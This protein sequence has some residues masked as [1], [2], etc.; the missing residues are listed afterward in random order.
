MNLPPAHQHQGQTAT[1]DKLKWER[2]LMHDSA[3]EYTPGRT[4][5]V[6]FTCGYTQALS[7][8]VLEANCSSMD[9]C[10]AS[11][12]RRVDKLDGR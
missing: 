2:G 9:P 12:D 8:T 4:H 7:A 6:R 5:A 3:E 11:T 10:C 1:G